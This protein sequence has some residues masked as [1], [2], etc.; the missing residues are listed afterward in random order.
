[1]TTDLSS[2]RPVKLRL[3]VATS[4]SPG[5]TLRNKVQ[6]V[7]SLLSLRDTTKKR[8][9]ARRALEG[10]ANKAHDDGDKDKDEDSK[11]DTKL[12]PLHSSVASSSID[13]SLYDD[14][15]IVPS[16]L[17]EMEFTFDLDTQ[18]SFDRISQLTGGLVPDLSASDDTYDPEVL[19]KARLLYYFARYV[20]FMIT[21]LGRAADHEIRPQLRD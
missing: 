18:A 21:V 11:P 6:I 7:V 15:V 12:V 9:E 17:P 16:D 10:P 2:G 3:S 13:M 5:S 20:V 14:Q 8:S 1:M 4:N 19:E